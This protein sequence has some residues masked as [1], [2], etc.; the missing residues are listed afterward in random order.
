MR[1]FCSRDLYSGFRR[2]AMK[3][4]ELVPKLPAP[5]QR[6]A[7]ASSS[8]RDS[9]D[10]R[11]RLAD[12]P[13]APPPRRHKRSRAREQLSVRSTKLEDGRKR[14]LARLVGRG[15]SSHPSDSDAQVREG[16]RD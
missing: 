9:R 15:W 12:W 5:E 6:F 11:R 3:F 1:L 16:E 13:S 2:L 8:R 4:D 10:T 14:A 7:A